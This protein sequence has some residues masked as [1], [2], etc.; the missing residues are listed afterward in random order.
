MDKS[1]PIEVEYNIRGGGAKAFCENY[2]K[3]YCQ[4]DHDVL[5]M[6]K[7]YA[8]LLNKKGIPQLQQEK[9][10]RSIGKDELMEITG[11]VVRDVS[12]R[13]EKRFESVD[14][15][16]MDKENFKF[17][18]KKIETSVDVESNSIKLDPLGN[19][20]DVSQLTHELAHIEVPLNSLLSEV[21]PHVVDLLSA[22][23]VEKKGMGN[24]DDV[25]AKFFDI[26]RSIAVPRVVG[27]MDDYKRDGKLQEQNIIDFSQYVLG[28][29]DREQREL[30][31]PKD[32]YGKSMDAS[33]YFIGVTSALVIVEKIKSGEIKL[34]DVFGVLNDKERSE[35]QRLTELGV[36]TQS[37]IAATQNYVSKHK[38][39]EYEILNEK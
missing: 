1:L 18:T 32:Q 26:L 25:H 24:S 30:V 28:S 12:P 17:R 35:A 6:F 10:N 27:V 15:K 14:V 33:K 22:D 36:N 3:I 2:D 19:I 13:L 20:S 5:L 37:L 29:E 9:E 8:Q 34:D 16:Y 31:S 39:K 4:S 38:S 23:I 7:E 11:D 21:A